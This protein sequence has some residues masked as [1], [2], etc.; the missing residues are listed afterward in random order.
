MQDIWAANVARMQELDRRQESLSM[1]RLATCIPAEGQRLAAHIVCTM[2]PDCEVTASP[3]RVN[4]CLSHLSAGFM[5]LGRVGHWDL[6]TSTC[7][8]MCPQTWPGPRHGKLGLAGVELV[9][10]ACKPC[11]LDSS[12]SW[13]KGTSGQQLLWETPLMISD[14]GSGIGKV[15]FMEPFQVD[16]H[17]LQ[18]CTGQVQGM[19]AA[20]AMGFQ[21]ADIKAW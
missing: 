2:L 13:L 3:S 12:G 5:L 14:Q 16:G 6:L 17:F 19:T 4:G 18:A 10:R 11:F 15:R 8:L 20:L 7:N 21:L 1:G 9:K